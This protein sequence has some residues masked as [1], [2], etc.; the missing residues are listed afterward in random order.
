MKGGSDRAVRTNVTLP[1][2]DVKRALE[3]VRYL[4]VP[5]WYGLP[6][7]G[8]GFPLPSDSGRLACQNVPS[9]LAH[10]IP[11]CVYK[12]YGRGRGCALARFEFA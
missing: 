12:R 7:P 2:V 3:R 11:Q 5:A 4:S 10:S 8:G 6:Q 1:A 9:I